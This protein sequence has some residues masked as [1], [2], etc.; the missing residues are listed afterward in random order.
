M[1]LLVS[2]RPWANPN[3]WANRDD[4]NVNLVVQAVLISRFPAKS[5]IAGRSL[6][7]GNL[8][9]IGG[10]PNFRLNPLE[11][12]IDQP[13]LRLDRPTFDHAELDNRIP[14]GTA[15]WHEEIGRIKVKKSMGA[16]VG[17][18]G[19]RFDDTGMD[20]VGQAIANGQELSSK[21][22]DFDL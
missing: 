11:Q 16:F 14:I 4:S 8:N 7:D 1:R 6:G 5:P 13:L 3:P 12:Q 10:N 15:R 20:R 17:G 18:E 9:V 21:T 22:V 2:R 19:Q